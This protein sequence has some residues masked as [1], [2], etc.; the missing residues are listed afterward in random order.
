MALQLTPIMAVVLR[1]GAVAMATY[2]V[3]R[4]TAPCRLS[5]PVEDEMDATPEGLTL[6]KSDGQVNG[7]WRWTRALRIGRA[8]SGVKVDATL[9]G[10]LKVERAR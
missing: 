3:T 7:S 10:R 1:Y 9:L 5:Q 8:A 6:R 4:M 2:A